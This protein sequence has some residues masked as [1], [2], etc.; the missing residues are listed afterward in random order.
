VSVVLSTEKELKWIIPI[1]GLAKREETIITD[2]L[3][4]IKIAKSSPAIRFVMRIR[5]EAHRFALSY[6]KK[7]RSKA[8]FA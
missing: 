7:L 4:K 8:I 5:D 2:K 1:I 3:E 6:H